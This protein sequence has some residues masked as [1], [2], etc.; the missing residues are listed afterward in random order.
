MMI[1]LA[2]GGAC[3]NT[4]TCAN[5]SP[6]ITVEQRLPPAG[7]IFNRN[8]TSNPVSS[9]NMVYVP[10]CTGDLH[11]GTVDNGALPDSPAVTQ[12]F[13][14]RPNLTAFLAWIKTQ[15][16]NST[17]VLLTGSS[18]GGFAAALNGTFVQDQFGASIPVTVIDDSGPI[19]SQSY[20]QPCLTGAYRAIWGLDASIIQDCG[21][22]CKVDLD[23]QLKIVD[24]FASRYSNR[25]FGLIAST[26][27]SELPTFLGVD[28]MCQPAQLPADAIAKG[29]TDYRAHFQGT[30]QS[31]TYYLAATRHTYLAGDEFYGLDP[32]GETSPALWVKRV[33]AGEQNL[34][35]GP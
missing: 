7:G 11:S 30:K 18:A 19:F 3:L 29:L 13:M 23:Y 14:G 33:L 17:Q 2:G 28:A 15:V 22:S 34:N 6:E 21:A 9:W 4:A 32:R 31:S 20:V 24:N 26:Q 1:F 16:P 27:D 10:Y 35:L 5:N 25:S 12:H 8:N